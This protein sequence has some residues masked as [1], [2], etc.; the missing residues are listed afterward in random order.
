VEATV[1]RD[2]VPL[3]AR[4]GQVGRATSTCWSP[5]LKR[6]IALASV[7]RRCEGA[8]TRLGMEWS[9]DGERGWVQATVAPLPF[10]DLPRKRDTDV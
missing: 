1:S 8:G 2:P 5:M 3:V 9:V 7:D 4:R 6:M 10:L